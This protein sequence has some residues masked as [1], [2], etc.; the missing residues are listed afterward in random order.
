MRW[1]R[2]AKGGALRQVCFRKSELS[3]VNLF[4]SCE[5]V[6]P[7]EKHT[8]PHGPIAPEVRSNLMNIKWPEASGN[9]SSSTAI[10]AGTSGESRVERSAP[11][12]A[13]TRTVARTQPSE[14]RKEEEKP[15]TVRLE[16]NPRG[17]K[18]VKKEPKETE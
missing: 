1:S 6:R 3:V 7:G 18:K 17:K 11:V 16:S 15:N 2:K 4:L 9:S 13:V 5:T 14:K 8:R 12:P 10:F